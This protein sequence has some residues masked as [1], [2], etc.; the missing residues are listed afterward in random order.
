M[1]RNR[2]QPSPPGRR[3]RA[4]K[5]FILAHLSDPHLGPLPR[6][7]FRELANKRLFGYLSWSRRRRFVHRP[8]VLAALERDLAEQGADHVAVTGDLT[9]ISLPGEFEAAAVWL[10]RLG[11]PERVSVVPGN[12]DAYVGLPWQ[13][14]LGHWADYMA[15][16]GEGGPPAGPDGFPFVRQRGDIAIVG[17]STAVPTAVHLAS[18]RLGAAQLA[19]L[20]DALG[21]L[22]RD[23]LCRVVLLHHP[24]A[25]ANVPRRKC[26]V[27]AAGFRD[28]VAA[29]GAELV[30]HGHDHSF[31][32]A[33]LPAGAG[34]ARVLG[35]PSASAARARG[36][37]LLA[38]Y[39][40][41]RIARDGARW[42]LEVTA[43]GFDPA[44]GA[45]RNVDVG[46]LGGNVAP[47]HR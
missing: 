43:R 44:S 38:Q 33:L 17:L 18:G 23:G 47:H 28:V 31:H 24:P 32:A 8:E 16:D 21:R 30:L 41:H 36:R 3:G 19:R 13:R 22:G 11:P 25:Q 26:L 15:G 35:V 10:R 9:N 2:R 39:L 42:H 1:L 46:T 14:S 34:E 6:P 29:H 4:S 37:H 27:D 40:L 20:G 45:F 12:H 7:R 5:L